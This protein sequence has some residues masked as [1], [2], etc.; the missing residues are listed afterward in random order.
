MM[1]II[2]ICI[3]LLSGCQCP[4]VEQYHPDDVCKWSVK[5]HRPLA[6]QLCC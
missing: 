5:Q 1:Y 3:Y 6:E 4:Y 2:A